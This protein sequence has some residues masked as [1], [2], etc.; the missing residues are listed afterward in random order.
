MKKLFYLAFTISFSMFLYSCKSDTTSE[1][2]TAQHEVEYK[3][4]GTVTTISKIRY[5]NYNGDTLTATNVNP[6]WSYK[7]SQKGNSG[8]VTYLEVTISNQ[9]GKVVLAILSDG[10]EIVKDTVEA[11]PTGTLTFARGTLVP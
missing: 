1:P 9:T 8:D 2:Q 3:T 5:L 11:Y 6:S 10:N 4:S 7:W